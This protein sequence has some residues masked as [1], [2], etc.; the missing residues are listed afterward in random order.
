MPEKNNAA[1]V[2]TNCEAWLR[3]ALLKRW[4]LRKYL[5]QVREQTLR[6]SVGRRLQPESPASAKALGQDP[7]CLRSGE[8]AG[9]SGG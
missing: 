1:K 3:Q 9:A 6:V 8:E 7:S 5:K 4:H 2:D